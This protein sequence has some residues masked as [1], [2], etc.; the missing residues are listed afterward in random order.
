MMRLGQAI[1]CPRILALHGTGRDASV[2]AGYVARSL[3]NELQ[4]NGDCDS[5]TLLAH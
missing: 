1:Y 5:F 4:R 2:G 3:V